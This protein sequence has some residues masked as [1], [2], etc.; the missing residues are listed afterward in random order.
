[1]YIVNKHSPNRYMH[2]YA[3]THPVSQIYIYTMYA[4]M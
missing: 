3:E 2:L 1:M 4:N